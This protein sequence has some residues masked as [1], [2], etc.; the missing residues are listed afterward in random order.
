MAA[1]QAK[2]KSEAKKKLL[3]RFGKDNIKISTLRY[4]KRAS[5][6]QKKE[7]GKKLKWYRANIK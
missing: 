4:M 5:E 7:Y 3:K 2:N 1:I 6:F